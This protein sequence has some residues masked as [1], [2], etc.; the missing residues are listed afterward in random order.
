MGLAVGSGSMVGG[1]GSV[2]GSGSG[3]GVAG[4]SVG[5]MVTAVSVAVGVIVPP[6]SSTVAVTTGVLVITSVGMRVAVRVMGRVIGTLVVISTVA[7]IVGVGVLGI[8]HESVVWQLLHLPRG[9]LEGLSPLW[10]ELQLVYV[11]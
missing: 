11:S 3:V 2:V 6:G 4:M 1:G 5:W 10:Q 8:D 9:W 7:V